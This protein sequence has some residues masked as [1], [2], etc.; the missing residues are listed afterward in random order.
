MKS[1]QI[2]RI[3]KNNEIIKRLNKKVRIFYSYK[4]EKCCDEF[5][6]YDRM[7]RKHRHYAL[8]GNKHL[9]FSEQRGMEYNSIPNW[10]GKYLG[11]VLECQLVYV[12]IK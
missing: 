7:K 9:R 4:Q 2:K 5:D 3:S 10:G 6:L 12:C 11:V 8:V 1:K